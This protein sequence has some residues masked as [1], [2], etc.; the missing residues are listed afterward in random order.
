MAVDTSFYPTRQPDPI[1]PLQLIGQYAGASSALQQNALLQQQVRGRVALG[2]LISQDTDAQGQLNQN[3]LMRDVAQDPDARIYALQTQAEARNAN[4]LTPYTT[5][6]QNTGTYVQK[7]EP[8][9]QVL[10]IGNPSQQANNTPP[11]SQIDKMHAHINAVHDTLQNLANKPDV[12]QSDVIDAVADTVAHPDTDFHATDGAALLSKIPSGPGGSPPNSQQLHGVIQPMLQQVTQTK[13][14]LDSRYPSSEQQQAQKVAAQFA[15]PEEYGN[16]PQQAPEQGGAMTAP[17]MG[18]QQNQQYWMNQY[19]HIRQ[20]A[21]SVPQ[22]QAVLQKIMTLSKNGAPSGT[23]AKDIYQYLAQRGVSMPGITEPAV[24]TQELAKYMEQ[25]LLADGMPESDRRLQAL[26]SAFTNPKQLPQAIQGLIPFLE[27][28]NKAKLLKANFFGQQAGQSGGSNFQQV[29]DAQ[30]KWNNIFD[31][32]VLEYN[33]L[34]PA[35]RRAY[36][37]ELSPEDAKELVR[38]SKEMKQV[39][40]LP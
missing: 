6:D 34:A 32:R 18:A 11:Q 9:S 3:A 15:A 23:I 5:F 40:I 24:Q 33:S 12:S 38:K 10:Q 21:D 2:R 17:P 36:A 7:Q 31:P 30:T 26:E 28:S 4:P 37:Q 14:L 13:A 8:Y 16:T 29:Q 39:G 19:Q 1:N 20:E 35:D 25:A 22:T 27:A